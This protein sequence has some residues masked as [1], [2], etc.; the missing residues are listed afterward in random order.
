M[1]QV[2]ARE[3]CLSRH[4]GVHKLDYLLSH[5]R[6]VIAQTVRDARDD[7]LVDGLR[8]SMQGPAGERLRTRTSCCIIDGS[9]RTISATACIVVDRSWTPALTP[10]Y[11]RSLSHRPKC[12]ANADSATSF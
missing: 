10:L 2:P 1:R 9:R 6:G 4:I 7:V 11:S 12:D 3:V 8:V 5:T